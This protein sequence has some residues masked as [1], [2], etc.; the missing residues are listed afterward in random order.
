MARITDLQTRSDTIPN[1]SGAV[2]HIATSTKAY[3]PTFD[4]CATC[5]KKFGVADKAIDFLAKNKVKATFFLTGEWITAHP[6]A[7]RRII[8][9]KNFE[10]GFHGF[11]HSDLASISN[12]RVLD[13]EI[14]GTRKV[15]EA[16]LTD[17]QHKGQLSTADYEQRRKA[18]LFRFPYGTF[19][20]TSLAAVH[21]AGLIPIQWNGTSDNALRPELPRGQK[22]EGS[23][24]LA[25]A[26]MSNN[27]VRATER[28]FPQLHAHMAEQG[29]QA[30]T[31]SE[32]MKTGKVV[33]THTPEH[34]TAS[35]RQSIARNQ[36][37]NAQRGY[38]VD[39]MRHFMATLDTKPTVVPQKFVWTLP[40]SA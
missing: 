30:M 2:H 22:L 12:R 21:Q 13:H 31:V 15:Y 8:A 23:I 36:A 28:T 40:S 33:H 37:D 10:I 39:S 26:N 24:L 38:G 35:E 4:C 9:N 34:M 7:A 6:E 1:S 27:A 3:A 20:E 16:L 5:S 11:S 14:N 19:N 18:N 32:L 25:H 29:F 17:M